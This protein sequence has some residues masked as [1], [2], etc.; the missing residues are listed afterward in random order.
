MA[1]CRGRL[2]FFGASETKGQSTKVYKI[3]RGIANVKAHSIS[4]Q[5]RGSKGS[6]SLRLKRELRENVSLR[7]KSILE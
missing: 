5:N 7:G 1:L 4:P 3:R 6:L 2:F